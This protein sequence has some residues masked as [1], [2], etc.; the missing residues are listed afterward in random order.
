MKIGEFAKACGISVS[1][2]RYYDEQGMLCPVYIDRFTGYRYYSR[3]QTEVYRRIAMLKDA[4]F[5]LAEIKIILETSDGEVIHEIFSRKKS[6]L[7][8]V[9]QNLGE[10]EKFILKVDSMKQNESFK[11]A[12]ENVKFPFENDESVIGRWEIISDDDSC[13]ALGGK[14]RQIFFLPDGEWYWCYSWTKGK[15]L[16]DDGINAYASDYVT[17]RREDGLYMTIALKSYDYSESGKTESVTLRKLDGKRYTK[18]EIARQEDI[19]LPFE[20]DRRVLGRWTAFDFI[21]R[22]EEFSAEKP[23]WEKQKLYFKEIEFFENGG[24]VSIYGDEII[25]GDNMQT[26]TKGYVLRKWNC[27]ACAYEIRREGSRDFLIIEW[28]SGDYRWGGFETDYYVF[29]KE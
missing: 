7:E 20:E 12:R 24:C 5:S 6:A 16:Y 22:K 1:A 2:L 9:I 18:E 4:G 19:A 15:F 27:T 14:K 10:T 3:V 13:T 29:V 17:E 28:K 11:P 23:Y 21:S 26:W 25:S 8:T